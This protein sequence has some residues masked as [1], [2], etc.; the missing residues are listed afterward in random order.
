MW[1]RRGSRVQGGWKRTAIRANVC[2]GPELACFKTSA[3]GW[4]SFVASWSPCM[5]GLFCWFSSLLPKHRN[6]GVPSS[7]YSS[8]LSCNATFPSSC[9]W[10]LSSSSDTSRRWAQPPL[11]RLQ[12]EPL[13]PEQYFCNASTDLPS[14]ECANPPFAVHIYTV[15]VLIFLSV[16][17]TLRAVNL[18]S[19][20]Q[21]WRQSIKILRCL[22]EAA[23]HL[24][25]GFLILTKDSAGY[26]RILRSG[27]RCLMR[28]LSLETGCKS[29]IMILV[30]CDLCNRFC[31]FIITRL[32]QLLKSE[33]V[34]RHYSWNRISGRYGLV[35]FLLP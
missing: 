6:P 18:T 7:S 25:L 19:P 33:Q 23:E 11:S 10:L 26:L 34:F 12:V 28:L 22:R 9:V 2:V 31:I 27:C 29:R 1:L 24:C 4:S 17:L 3:A 21:P 13:W 30:T 32:T 15:D 35:F 14:G 8:L 16:W 20:S 5:L